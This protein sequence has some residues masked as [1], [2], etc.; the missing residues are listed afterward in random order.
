MQTLQ[1]PIPI[2]TSHSIPLR[3]ILTSFGPSVF[4]LNPGPPGKY[5]ACYI[6]S[7]IRALT[8]VSH[9]CFNSLCVLDTEGPVRVK[10]GGCFGIYYHTVLIPFVLELF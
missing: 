8:R 9:L 3:S 6:L 10:Y 1:Q 7:S 5:L 2:S 4:F